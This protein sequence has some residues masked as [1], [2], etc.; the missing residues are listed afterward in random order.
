MIWIWLGI[1]ILFALM[2]ASFVA[3]AKYGRRE[4]EA[5]LDYVDSKIHGLKSKL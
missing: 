4:A 3:G 5:A 1:A 2:I